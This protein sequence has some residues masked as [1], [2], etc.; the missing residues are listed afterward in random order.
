MARYR[1]GH[2]LGLALPFDRYAVAHIQPCV[3]A[4]ALNSVDQFSSRALAP[5]VV[6]KRRIDRHGVDGAGGNDDPGE[7]VSSDHDVSSR[8]ALTFHLERGTFDELIDLLVRVL[9]APGDAVIDCPPAFGMY[10]FSARV[11]G[12]RII[13]AA[14]RDDF[15][16]DL[17]PV[18]S[19]SETAKAIFVASPNNPTG[20]PLT[21]EELDALLATGLDGQR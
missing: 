19:A 9:L 14:R 20:N 16:L 11:A 6:V 3:P 2:R 17:D 10:G 15:S 4:Q 1:L 13:E 7:R 18:R 8:E 5:Q 21:D 12:G